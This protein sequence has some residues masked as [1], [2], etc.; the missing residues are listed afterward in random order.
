M[1]K[2][3]TVLL[4]LLIIPGMI[5]AQHEF[6]RDSSFTVYSAWQKIKTD[7]PQ[8]TPVKPFVSA[9]FLSLTNQ[10]YRV[11]G[12]RQL[13]M[14]IFL[15]NKTDLVKRPAILM[16]HGGGWAS[17]NKSHLVPLAQKL[18]ID[19]FIGIAV[20]YRLSP[21]ALYPAAICDL[22]EAIR[23]VKYNAG[24]YGID[25]TRIA[26]LGTSAGATLAAFMATTGKLSR[27]D[28]PNSVYPG[29]SS[30][31]QALINIDGVVDFTDP[32]ESAKDDDPKKPSAGA[33]FF[34]GTYQEMPEKWV[35]ASPINYVD[36]HSPPTLYIN[37]ALERFHAGRE[38]FLAVLKANH[39]YYEIHTIPHTPHPFWLF[40]PWFDETHRYVKDFLTK[41][42]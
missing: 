21:E 11:R 12:N 5:T 33:R 35:E 32:N 38:P 1:L 29:I 37:S 13:H 20:E 26:V 24:L 7:Y 19:G 8:A 6:P 10:V 36:K 41:L 42:F 34:G 9:D 27:F 23:F 15:P 39:T 25:T 18:A 28:D 3:T 4:L 31:V 40:H 30:V 16:I 2:I 17:G 22:K 14:D